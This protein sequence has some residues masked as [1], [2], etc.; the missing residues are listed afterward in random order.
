MPDCT[1][2]AEARL[3]LR[4]DYSQGWAVGLMDLGDLGKGSALADAAGFPAAVRDCDLPRWARLARLQAK[5]QPLVYLGPGHS[6]GLGIPTQSVHKPVDEQDAA[7]S[8]RSSAC[9]EGGVAWSQIADPEVQARGLAKVQAVQKFATEEEA[10]TGHRIVTAESLGLLKPRLWERRDADVRQQMQQVQGSL[11]PLQ[12]VP[13][14]WCLGRG[15]SLEGELGARGVAAK[16]TQTDL[17]IVL[18][19]ACQTGGAVDLGGDV[20]VESGDCVCR[21]CCRSRK[22]RQWG[23]ETGKLVG[24]GEAVECCEVA[25]VSEV[26]E[27]EKCAAGKPSSSL[28]RRRRRLQVKH[29]CA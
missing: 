12:G 29:H 22:R 5:G 8:W 9:A 3:R 15:K 1:W 11:G 28:Q 26:A 18:D 24:S 6:D 7:W 17:C 20:A 13:D 4:A 23:T 16:E 21:C 19:E 2:L 14:R 10:V 25:A 27:V